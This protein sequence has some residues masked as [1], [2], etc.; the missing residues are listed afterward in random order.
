MGDLWW[1]QANATVDSSWF[2]VTPETPVSLAFGEPYSPQVEISQYAL[3]RFKSNPTNI[4]LEMLILGTGSELV[5]NLSHISGNKTDIPL[6]ERNKSQPK[7]ATYTI[8]TM[9]GAIVAQGQ[10]EYG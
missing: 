7:E 3:R 4:R 1:L 2:T 8:S 5:T 9:D 6:S 10:F